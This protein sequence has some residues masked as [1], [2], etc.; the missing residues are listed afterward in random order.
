MKNIW[1]AAIALA[2]ALCAP[3]AHAGFLEDLLARPAIQNL[4]GR[5][6]DLQVTVRNCTN[7][8]FRQ[9]NLAGCEQEEQAGRLAAIPNCVP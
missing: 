5:Q 1:P 3:L 8:A 7:P 9:R 2:G 6:S 4:L